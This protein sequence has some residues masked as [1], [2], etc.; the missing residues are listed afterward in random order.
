[1]AEEFLRHSA[2]ELWHG[3]YYLLLGKFA[4]RLGSKKQN[5]KIWR[6]CNVVRKAYIKLGLRK[7]WLLMRFLPLKRSQGLGGEA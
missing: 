6:T 1:M 2:F 3:Y 5:R 4:V 7:V